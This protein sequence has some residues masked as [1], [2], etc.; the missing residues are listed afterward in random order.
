MLDYKTENVFRIIRIPRIYVCIRNLYIICLPDSLDVKQY[1]LQRNLRVYFRFVD[2]YWL[3]VE[4][5]L[6]LSSSLSFYV[7]MYVFFLYIHLF[8]SM[9]HYYGVI[10][11]ALLLILHIIFYLFYIHFKTVTNYLCPVLC[12]NFFCLCIL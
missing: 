10:L 8:A 6:S 1:K 3:S 12:S 2:V 7:C 11:H 4:N 9:L 5:F